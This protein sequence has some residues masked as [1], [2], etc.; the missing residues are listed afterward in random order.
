MNDQGYA[1][2]AR[3]RDVIADN[4]DLLAVL[5]RFDISLGFGEATVSEVCNAAGVDTDT[6]ISVA[7]FISGHPVSSCKVNLTSLVNYLRNAHSYFLGYVATNIR[8]LMLQA[9][10]TRDGS[11]LALELLKF[12]DEYI[13]E[14]SR[15]MDYEDRVVFR[16]VDCLLSGDDD[17]AGATGFS[18]DTFR[19]S[20]TPVHGK[21]SD[22]KD[23]L[24]CHFTADKGR[25]DMMNT[26]LY[27]I[28]TFERELSAH[29]RLED[30]LFIP[31]V[32]RIAGDISSRHSQADEKLH[33]A[34]PDN[35]DV[36]LTQREREIVTEVTRGLS[37]K[38]IAEKLFLSVHTVATHRRN[39]CAKLN[40]H[41]AS[42]L[43][44]YGIMHGLS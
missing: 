40:L 1:A 32:S 24:L 3:M 39:I 23:L 42:A 9:V 17:G 18:I 44:L 8:Q 7:N 31:E 2:S 6:F 28:V 26:L 37:N 16:F 10:N 20:H 11:R 43:T 35:G 33:K 34:L 27:D 13:E 30:D 12:F 14:V 41:S 19:Q 25:V 38:E 5:T 15:H 29:C 36:V 22:L 4:P 21:L